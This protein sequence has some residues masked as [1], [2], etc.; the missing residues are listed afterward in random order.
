MSPMASGSSSAQAPTAQEVLK[1]EF[2]SRPAD[3]PMLGGSRPGEAVA[4]VMNVEPRPERRAFQLQ[5]Y[6]KAYLTQPTTR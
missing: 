1:V 2:G 4:Q 3:D 6:R 5:L